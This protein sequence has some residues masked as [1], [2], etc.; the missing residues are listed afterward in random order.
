MA[1]PDLN[2]LMQ[3]FRDQI[4]TLMRIGLGDFADS[5]NA[6]VDTMLDAARA[7]IQDWVNNPGHMMDVITRALNEIIDRGDVAIQEVFVNYAEAV[8]VAGENWA[9]AAGLSAQDLAEVQQLFMTTA[10]ANNYQ[11]I[12]QIITPLR[13]EIT[14]T[15][16][17]ALSQGLGPGDIQL[18]LDDIGLPWSPTGQYS[19]GQR[20]AMIAYTEFRRIGE[21][22]QRG[23]AQ[24]AGVDYCYNQLLPTLRN[25]ADICIAATAA[26]LITIEEM[27]SKYMMPP[28]HPNCGCAIYYADPEWAD[29]SSEEDYLDELREN[30]VDVEGI[31]EEWDKS[32]GQEIKNRESWRENLQWENNLIDQL[33]GAEA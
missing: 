2:R 11:F 27:E 33:F 23:M 31:A 25:H 8:G 4:Q 1:R 24:I 16:V 29:L 28:R 7:G 13:N 9:T 20:A 18:M 10:Q 30:G 6:T 5:L 12:R 21:S 15:F 3:Q 17:N 26:G 22:T 19:P 32:G 14:Q